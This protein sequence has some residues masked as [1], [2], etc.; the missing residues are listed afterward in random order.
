MILVDTSVW[1]D[2]LRSEA[3]ELQARLRHYDV[4][5]H[6]MIIGEIACGTFKAS[7]GEDFLSNLW[8][9]PIIGELD[10]L[11]VVSEIVSRGLEGRGVTFI[12]F[13]LLFAV[14]AD[15]GAQLWT[16]DKKLGALA[17]ELGVAFS[18]P[19]EEQD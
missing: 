3:Q 11:K 14:L 7:S 12:D 16:R 17:C 15:E 9:L 4:L 2:Y 10:H 8:N 19:T 5:I 6:P 1:I 18:E 13:H